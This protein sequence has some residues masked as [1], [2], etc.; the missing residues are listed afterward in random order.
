MANFKENNA[1]WVARVWPFMEHI[2]L[3]RPVLPHLG[4]EL[5]AICF[6][7]SLF[8]EEYSGKVSDFFLSRLSQLGTGSTDFA[9]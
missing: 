7:D 1:F 2:A 4:S 8:S 3:F 9:R 6:L 5:S